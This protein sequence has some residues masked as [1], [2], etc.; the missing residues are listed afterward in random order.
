MLHHFNCLDCLE[1]KI[2]TKITHINFISNN[3]KGIQNSLKTP[4]IFDFLKEN[5]SKNGVLCLEETN[6]LSKKEIKWKVE[7]KG[8]FFFSYAKTN[9]C[10]VAIGYTGKRSFNFLKKAND[11]NGLF[12][13]LESMIYVR[14]F[15]LINLCNPKTEKV[16]VYTWEKLNLI[17][18]ISDEL[19]NKNNNSSR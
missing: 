3:V 19:E 11:E 9:S 2:L 13:I 10:G 16:Q 6:V 14:V 4:K 12:L 18:E 5:M 1:T 15:I 8:A 7:L 17:L